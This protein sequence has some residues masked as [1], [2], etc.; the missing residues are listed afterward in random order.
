[1]PGECVMKLKA[2]LMGKA[3]REAYT[4]HW[5]TDLTGEMEGH[6]RHANPVGSFGRGSTK[7]G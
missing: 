1:M 2:E 5:M 4:R 3:A 6:T 7:E